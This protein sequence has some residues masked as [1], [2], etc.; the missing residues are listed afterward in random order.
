MSLTELS[1]IEKDLCKQNFAFYDKAK[2][3]YVE[4]FELPMVLTS[5]FY[6][7]LSVVLSNNNFYFCSLWLQFVRPEDRIIKL[8]LGE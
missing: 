8:I 3:G 1:V 4:L 6:L 5:K 7:F 2:Q